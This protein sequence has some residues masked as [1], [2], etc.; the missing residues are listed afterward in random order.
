MAWLWLLFPLL[1]LASTL[2]LWR[3][4]T[5]LD[6]ERSGLHAGVDALGPLADQARAV[7][8]LEAPGGATGQERVDR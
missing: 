3:A 1:I 2:A 6:R 4:T 5:A 7:R 8:A